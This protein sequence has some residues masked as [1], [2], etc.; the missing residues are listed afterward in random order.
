[1]SKIPHTYSAEEEHL[2][3]WTHGIAAISACIATV[4]LVIQG[5]AISWQ[6]ACIMLVYGLSMILLFAAS[7]LY[8]LSTSEQQRIWLKKLDHTAIYYLIAGT[9]TPFLA[10]FIPT[11]KAKILLVA[12]WGIALLG[13]CF[14]LFFVQRF[15][16]LSLIA[17]I[18]MGW[19][20]VLVMDDMKTYLSSTAMQLLI[21]GGV[22]YTVGTLFYAAKK[23]QYTHAIWHVFVVLGAASHCYAIWSMLHGA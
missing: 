22:L 7:T 19:L 23:Y 13:T 17:Y 15:Q 1:M 10:L 3:A 6:T 12:L 9:Y 4:F 11:Q 18:V 20:A 2:N 16:K 5:Y 14:K 21:L 8:H